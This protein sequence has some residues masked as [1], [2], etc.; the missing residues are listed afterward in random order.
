MFRIGDHVLAKC[1]RRDETAVEAVI[2]NIKNT[3]DGKYYKVKWAHLGA[4]YEECPSWKS[5][6]LIISKFAC[7]RIWCGCCR[8][9]NCCGC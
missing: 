7:K 3:D 9:C 4:E 8:N 5:K 1:E 2:V 6:D